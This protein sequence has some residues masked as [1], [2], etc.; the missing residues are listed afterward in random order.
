MESGTSGI[1]LLDLWDS[2]GS[3]LSAVSCNQFQLWS[4]FKWCIY[5]DTWFLRRLHRFPMLISSST[6]PTIFLPIAWHLRCTPE[7]VW[8]S[9]RHLKSVNPPYAFLSSWSES[10][11]RVTKCNYAVLP[12][13]MN[14]IYRQTDRQT[15]YFNYPL[16]G[17]PGTVANY[18]KRR[19]TLWHQ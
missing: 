9:K 14:C 7:K 6:P 17:V 13:C 3:C 19:Q 18:L 11:N 8:I 10:S 16:K 4:K 2:G 12:A 15:D 5:H 1:K